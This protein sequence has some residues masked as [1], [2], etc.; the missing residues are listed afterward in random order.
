MKNYKYYIGIDPDVDKSGVAYYE[1]ESKKLELSNLT[2]FQLFD[3]LR[4]AKG[5]KLD[6]EKLVIYIEAGWLNKSNWHKSYKNKDGRLVK[7]SE[8]QNEKIS[9]NTGA[10]H[11]TGKKI[12]E[13]CEYLELDYVIVKPTSSKVNSEY[14]NKLTNTI[15]RTNQEQRDAAMLVYG[16]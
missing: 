9:R 4:F 14:F 7:H 3:Y 8:A 1:S 6:F 2:F 10:N 13:M 12:V 15:G 11:E 5:A 16:M